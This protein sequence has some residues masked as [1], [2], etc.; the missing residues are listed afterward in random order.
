[1][2]FCLETNLISAHKLCCNNNVSVEFTSFSFY[3]KDLT[4]SAPLL[5][6][7]LRM[8]FTNGKA[9]HHHQLL[10]LLLSSPL[11]TSTTDLGLPSSSILLLTR[12]LPVSTTSKFFVNSCKCNKTHKFSFYTPSIKSSNPL[13]YNLFWCL[14]TFPVASIDGFHYYLI[15][16]DHFTM[17]IWLFPMKVKSEVS[18]ILPIFKSVIE[19]F[20][21]R[22]II[23]FYSDNGGEFI[24][25]KNFFE[26]NEFLIASLPLIHQNTM[27]LLSV[28]TTI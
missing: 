10:I 28:V 19:M 23:T 16:V 9:S 6:G 7:N 18:L 15:F 20:F 12:N 2:C 5:A 3:V 21:K 22:S 8:M 17:Y 14:G 26:M 11:P 1:M 25:L 27:H 4:T 13:E 24:I